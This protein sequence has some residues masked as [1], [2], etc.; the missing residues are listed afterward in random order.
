MERISKFT[1]SECVDIFYEYFK[2][3]EDNE[4]NNKLRNLPKDELSDLI[5]KNIE[6]ENTERALM[7]KVYV[8]DKKEQN[9]IMKL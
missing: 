7:C 6:G 3:R 4:I 8:T 5:F 1:S 2:N 9:L